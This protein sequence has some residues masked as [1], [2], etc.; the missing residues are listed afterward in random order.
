[1]LVIRK[2]D[3]RNTKTS[4][5]NHQNEYHTYDFLVLFIELLLVAAGG[6][7]PNVPERARAQPKANRL[8][9]NQSRTRATPQAETSRFAFG[10]ARARSGTFGGRPPAGH[11]SPITLHMHLVY[12]RKLMFSRRKRRNRKWRTKMKLSMHQPCT[13]RSYKTYFIWP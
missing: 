12:T 13:L 11:L 7:P 3:S 2:F 1:M 5:K 10:C 6:R 8:V 4:D 9:S